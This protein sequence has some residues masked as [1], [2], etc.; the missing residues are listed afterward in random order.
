MELGLAPLNLKFLNLLLED[1]TFI[2]LFLEVG[3]ITTQTFAV[4]GLCCG[5][6]TQKV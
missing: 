4:L 1:H 3:K 6:R 2:P 5:Y